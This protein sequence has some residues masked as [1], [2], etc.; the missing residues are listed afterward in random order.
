LTPSPPPR[1]CGPDD[2]DTVVDILVSAFYNDPTW[3]RLFADPLRRREQHARVWRVLVEGAIRYPTVWLSANDTATAL[4]IPP[5]VPDLSP[6]QEAAFAPMIEEMLDADAKPVMHAFETLE[7]AHPHDEPH[8]Y[9]TLLGTA[10]HHRGHGYG[11]RLLSD[12]LRVVDDAKMPAYLEAS[13]P[14]NV[15]L[16]ARYGFAPL[17]TVE[18]PGGPAITTMWRAATT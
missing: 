14:I 13:N 4:W 11:L 15:P 18:L 17:S 6:E 10:E 3:G 12:T 7:N 2:A 16:Y 8:Y 9:L 1:T 5:G